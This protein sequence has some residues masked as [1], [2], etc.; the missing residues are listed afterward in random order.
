MLET[1]EFVQ[2]LGSERATAILRTD[3]HETARSAMAAAIRGGFRIV[4]FT[5]TVPGALDLI[6]EFA[7]RGDVVVGAG[8]VLGA[9]EAR[10]CVSR[11]ASFL[12]SPITDEDVIRTANELGVA[13]IPGAHTP[14]EL[15]RAQRAG[16]P[17]QKLFPAPAG[18]P[19]Y[20]RA[21]LGPLPSLRI[22]PTSGVDATNAA[23]FLAAG[24]F[25]VGFV[26]P[27]FQPEWLARRDFA[28]I[29]ARARELLG[30]VAAA[31]RR[32]RARE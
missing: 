24:A 3:D 1:G 23:E 6:E 9:A 19:S 28:A 30:L 5:L 7:A 20:V 18:G 32:G 29:E 8:T 27:L 14:T 13:S 22:V 4:E 26:A 31:P 12:V 15:V 21:C 17:L 16:A 25:A 10:A 11:G 2:R